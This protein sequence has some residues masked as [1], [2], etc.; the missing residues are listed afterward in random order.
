[1]AKSALALVPLDD[2][3]SP[4]STAEGRF[5][6]G[7]TVDSVLAVSAATR[8]YAA[9]HARGHGGAIKVQ[10]ASFGDVRA[11]ARFVR[12]VA[13]TDAA[14]TV[15]TPP[16]LGYGTTNSGRRYLVTE[17][18]AGRTL[19][20]HSAARGGRFD[21]A[22][23][24]LVTERLLAVTEELH[25]IGIVHHDIEPTNV[26]ITGFAEIRLID[27]SAA[28]SSDARGDE[29]LADARV[30]RIT[31][32]A[33][34]EQLHG[35]GD[36]DDPRADI[37]GIGALLYWMLTGTVRPIAR[38]S[39]EPTGEMPIEEIAHLPSDVL[40]F[41]ELALAPDPRRRL[42]SAVVMRMAL[43]SMRAAFSGLAFRGACDDS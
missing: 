15:G 11:E 41:L 42:A 2:H 21:L 7:W 13:L 1:M 17:L 8:V 28:T 4:A 26:F 33:P 16:L 32:F 34:P 38:W 6:E 27:F 18:L 22:T 40:D 43:S 39:R 36:V 10:S 12:E 25:R 19:A 20:Q 30:S 37:F 3:L 14:S 29:I 9:T 35:T 23:A 31:G 5:V 24:L